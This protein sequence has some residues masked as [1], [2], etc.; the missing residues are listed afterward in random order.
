MTQVTPIEQ[1]LDG[2]VPEGRAVKIRGWIYRSRSQGK[3]N[4]VVVRDSTGILQCAVKK[5]V[6]KDDHFEDASKAL[7]ESAVIVEGTVKKDSRAPGGFE[8]QASHFHVLHFSEVF[9]IS[10]DQSTEFLLDVRHLW[11]RS[12][13]L[14][15]AMKVK[16]VVLEAIRE[17]C[18]KEGYIETTPPILSSSAAEGGS[19]LFEVPYF[20]KKAFLSQ[21]AQLH[22]E[23]LIFSLEKVYAITPSFRAE[24]SRTPKHLAE[25]WH[26]EGEAAHCS[27]EE[28]MAFEEKLVAFVCH[29]VARQCQKELAV[30][31]RNPQDLEKISAPFEKLAYQDAVKRLQKKGFKFKEGDDFG[32]DE[33]AALTEGLDQPVFVTHFPSSMKPFYMLENPDGTVNNHDLIA[34]GGG[35]IIGGSER[36]VDLQRIEKKLKKAGEKLENYAW[37]LDLRRFG[38]VQHSGFGL[39]VERLVK[40]VA[41]LEHIRDATAFPRVMNRA[42]P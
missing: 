37:Y 34:P 36:E 29:E 16:A 26:F 22:L 23:A 27:H 20:G 6:V 42:Y 31:G 10:K 4:F 18:K 39:G 11:L 28:I 12:R 40:W 14:T 32:A 19:T 24:K 35:E 41:G 15:A 1:V 5:G 2:H 13:E 21:S 33:E 7:L 38:S 30:L 9:P 25:Y 3:L 17:Y 8:L